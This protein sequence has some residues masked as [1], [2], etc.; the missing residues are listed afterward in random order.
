M[1]LKISAI[2]LKSTPALMR[3]TTE[4]M[5][6]LDAAELVAAAEATGGFEAA[7]GRLEQACRDRDVRAQKEG[8]AAA[9]AALGQY[10][11]LAARHYQVPSVR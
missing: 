6:L 7:V 4:A 10:L 5:E 3:L 8:A 1:L 2:Y 11:E 9:R